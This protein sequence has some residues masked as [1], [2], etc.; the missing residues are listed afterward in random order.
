[1]RS[2]WIIAHRGASGQA[3]E[4]TLAAF[5]RA[6]QMGAQFIET[7]L[8]L[9]R[10]AH[11]VAIHDGV[12]ERTTNG[13][14]LV[15][16]FTLAELRELDAG[17]WF[18]R[19]F[20]GERIPTLEEILEFSH[21]HD[22][23]FYLEVKYNAAWGMHHALVAA[24]RNASSAARTVVISFDPPTLLAVH[25]L[26]PA[27]MTGLLIEEREADFVQLANRAAVRQV[28]AASSLVTPGL[29]TQAHESDLHV[30]A[31]TVNERE[32]MRAMIAADVEGIMTDFPDRLR[33]TIEDTVASA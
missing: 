30:V 31:W 24:L 10:D 20:S 15:R 8:H 14:G 32:E 12:L 2:P 17:K 3:P 21:K 7:D 16:E 4:N 22:V 27:L 1:M 9:T 26:D 11:F 5:E 25:N 28:C 23:V 13:R 6:V 29:V 18:D 19:E 33:A